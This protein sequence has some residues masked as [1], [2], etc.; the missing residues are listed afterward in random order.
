MQLEIT[1]NHNIDNLQEAV[2]V[3]NVTIYTIA[4]THKEI[5]EKI[6]RTVKQIFKTTQLKFPTINSD[7]IAESISELNIENEYDLVMTSIFAGAK[8]YNSSHELRT[9]ISQKLL[10]KDIPVSVSVESLSNSD[11]LKNKY[12]DQPQ[13]LQIIVLMTVGL[14]LSGLAAFIDLANLEDN[15]SDVEIE[16]IILH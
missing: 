2:L 4:N 15:K 1:Y 11:Y 13:I 12:K 10:Y 16:K 9:I 5:D 7:K 14:F 3:N 6:I 8:A